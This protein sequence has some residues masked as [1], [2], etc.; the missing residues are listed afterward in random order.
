MEL[1]RG[2]INDQEQLNQQTDQKRKS[3]LK[4]LL[5]D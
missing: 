3:K 5:E 4:N 1:L 2:I